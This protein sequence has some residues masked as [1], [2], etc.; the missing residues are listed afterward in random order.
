MRRR[1]NM[2]NQIVNY[3]VISH[4]SEGK[5]N[6]LDSNIDKLSKQIVIECCSRLVA[7]MIL[8][9]I[10]N[11]LIS[12]NHNIEIIHNPLDKNIIDGIID[13][14]SNIGI[15]SKSVIEKDYPNVQTVSLNCCYVSETDK[16]CEIKDNITNNFNKAYDYFK[17][18]KG[19]HDDWEV[20]YIENINFSKADEIIEK[21]IEE[22]LKDINFDKKATIR[23]RFF[24]AIS[25]N[26][27]TNYVEEIINS[28]K[29]RYFIKGRPGTSKS[30]LLKKLAKTA[31]NKGIDVDVYYCA[32]DINSVDMLVLPE[33]DICIF[34]ST[35]PHEFFPTREDDII[36]DMYAELLEENFD[37]KNE[38]LLDEIKSKYSLSVTKGIAV[39]K[40]IVKLQDDLETEYISTI[41]FDLLAKM[42]ED[43]LEIIK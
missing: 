29:T 17:E 5:C 6:L 11:E 21:N 30:T 24:G 31:E 16:I 20:V 23:E 2:P 27:A 15:F 22:I 13:L 19:I 35:A 25:A 37:E 18:A 41:D 40:N 9:K 1:I 7:T 8:K 3:Y 12:K 26:G 14:N 32:S 4:N 10:S 39:L 28:K 43:I 36:I 33:L 38:E 42:Y 34:D